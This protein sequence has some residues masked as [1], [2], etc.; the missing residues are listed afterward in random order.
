MPLRLQLVA[1]LHD[2]DTNQQLLQ[3]VQQL[4]NLCLDCWLNTQLIASLQVQLTDGPAQLQQQQQE[5]PGL[6]S[7][8]MMSTA[9]WWSTNANAFQDCVVVVLRYVLKKQRAWKV[10]SCDSISRGMVMV[11]LLEWLQV[12]NALHRRAQG[13]LTT[14]QQVV[15]GL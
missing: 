8:R 6:V 10:L 9:H 14:L 15:G 3:I 5:R 4:H 1:H 12:G 2:A 11:C 13:Q 7:C